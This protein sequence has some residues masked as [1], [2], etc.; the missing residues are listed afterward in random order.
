MPIRGLQP[1]RLNRHHDEKGHKDDQQ[2]NDAVDLLGDAEIIHPPGEIHRNFSDAS[3]PG[4]ASGPAFGIAFI[5]ELVR[6]RVCFE[7]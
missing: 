1:H 4:I 6:S 7:S 3:P 5:I 2:C